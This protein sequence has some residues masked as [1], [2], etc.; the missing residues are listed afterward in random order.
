MSWF[1]SYPSNRQHVKINHK[2]SQPLQIKYGA[3]QG[4]ILGPLLFLL[5][6]NDPP[7]EDGLDLLSLF[8]DDATKSTA[9]TDVKNVEKSLQE[10][11]DSLTRWCSINRMVPISD[12]TKI[13]VIGTSKRSQYLDAN[14]YKLN[15]FLRKSKIKQVTEETLLGC[16]V[17]ENLSWASQIR[18]VRQIILYKLSILRKIKRFVPLS[19]CL[20]FHNYFVKPQF[21]YCCSVWATAFK[22]KYQYPDKITENGSSFNS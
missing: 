15:V 17:D 5:F 4:S 11:S 7:L 10:S 20:T 2:V 6:I 22:K 9:S 18:K 21:D 19:G 3:P 1:T 8:A 13:M 16:V 12:K 14:K